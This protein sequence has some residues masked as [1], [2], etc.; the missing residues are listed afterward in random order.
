MYNNSLVECR[1]DTK[2]MI[3]DMMSVRFERDSWRQYE[4]VVESTVYADAS[5]DEAIP[6]SSNS[7]EP[8]PVGDK[9]LAE[10][11]LPFQDDTSSSSYIDCDSLQM[12]EPTSTFVD[13]DTHK[14]STSF[15]WTAMQVL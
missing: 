11:W 13:R 3:M 7:I 10:G 8:G 1:L 14:V 9:V 6:Q 2:S 15:F 4:D 5:F 12:F